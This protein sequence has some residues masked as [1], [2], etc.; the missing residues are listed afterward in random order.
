M[1][2]TAEDTGDPYALVV[3]DWLMPQLDGI[4]TARL[5]IE[6]LSPDHRPA[7]ILVSAS[8]DKQMRAEALAL[9]ITSVLEKPVS[10]STLHD[11]LLHLLLDRVPSGAAPLSTGSHE[12]T[13]GDRHAGKRVLL[14]EDN[15]INQEV[16]L[17]LLR[18]AQLEVDVAETGVQA[19]EMAAMGR[20][21]VILMDM[22]MPEMDGLQA[23]TAIRN[24]PALADVPIIAMTANAFG[25]DRDACFAAGMNDHIA[26]PV[27]PPVLYETLGRWL[28]R[29]AVRAPLPPPAP[30]PPSDG[31]PRIEG[32]DVEQ[33]LS[34]FASNRKSYLNA[35]RR[36]ATIYGNGLAALEQQLASHAVSPA[37]QLRQE[38]HSM[39]GA[40]IA[41]GAT[42]LGEQGRTL[43]Q[44]LRRQY[45]V[46]ELEALLVEVRAGL[47]A[48]VDGLKAQLPE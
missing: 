42:R 45:T 46:E 44:V 5:M 21:D 41:I 15:F 34:Y 43:D 27:D 2:K 36:F 4:E 1:A 28:D 38:L 14:A 3:L 17:E 16:A 47:T 7:F 25:E 23:S 18:G 37:P 10:Y 48:I 33:G 40:A 13:L 20:Y 26:K 35:L 6:T 29:A 32:L 19:V 24:M 8:S 22:Q 12:R 31:L 11:H 30:P 39:A 9:D